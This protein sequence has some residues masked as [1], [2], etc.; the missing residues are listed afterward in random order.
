M[1]FILTFSIQLIY[2]FQC[3]RTTERDEEEERERRRE[4]RRDRGERERPSARRARKAG[5]LD[6][7]E[8]AWE[9]VRKGV[10]TTQVYITKHIVCIV[11]IVNFYIINAWFSRR[12]PKCSAKKLKLTYPLL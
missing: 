9:T 12:N 6:D 4:R 8:G 10:A 5:E 7:G 2:F 1:Y 3:N 11:N